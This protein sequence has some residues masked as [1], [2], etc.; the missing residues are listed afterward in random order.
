[1][2]E[3]LFFALMDRTDSFKFGTDHQVKLPDHFKRS[4]IVFETSGS[5]N[6][7][8]LVIHSKEGFLGACQTV[9]RVFGISQNDTY[10]FCFPHYYIARA[11]IYGRAF[12]SSCRVK[13][14]DE[15][16]DPKKFFKFIASNNVTI[17]SLVPTQLYDL[18]ALQKKAPHSLRIVFVSGGYLDDKLREKAMTLNWP[19]IETYGLTESCGMIARKTKGYFE[20]FVELELKQVDQELLIK[21]S[22]VAK[23]LIDDAGI[24]LISDWLSTGDL[25]EL[26]NKRFILIGRKDQ[27]VKIKGHFL[28]L[29]SINKQLRENGLYCYVKSVRNER[30]M[31]NLKLQSNDKIKAI[32]AVEFLTKKYPFIKEAIEVELEDFGK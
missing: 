20:V 3:E 10:G 30:N 15:K 16:W 12:V 21:G 22:Q 14:F 24:R 28:D 19:V 6:R 4:F 25:V 13:Q 8:K 7:K 29:S 11:L 27:M 1:M 5:T 32:K 18:V 2:N 17:L 23:A 31:H 26:S 9:C